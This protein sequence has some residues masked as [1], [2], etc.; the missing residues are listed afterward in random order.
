MSSVALQILQKLDRG[1]ITVDEAERF[2]LAG[3]TVIQSGG[4][5]SH[6]KQW[7]TAEIPTPSAMT[8]PTMFGGKSSGPWM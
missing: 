6:G 3:R 1:Q 7:A 4:V 5:I 2:L 8:L